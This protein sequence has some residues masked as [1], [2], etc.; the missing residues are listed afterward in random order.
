MSHL[1]LLKTRIPVN[2]L[3]PKNLETL[4]SE[5]SVTKFKKGKVIFKA[6]DTDDD[7][8]YLLEGQMELKPADSGSTR[9]VDADDDE[10]KYALAQLKPR[11]YTGKTVAPAIIARINSEKLDRLLSIDQMSDDWASTEGYEVTEFGGDAD[12]ELLVEMLNRDTFSQLPAESISELFSRLEPVS[13]KSNDVVIIQGEPGDY[14][15]IIK[16]GKFTVARKLPDGKVKKLAELGKGDVFGEEALISDKPRNASV[17]ATEEGEIMRLSKKD[18]DELLKPDL[19]AAISQ[20]EVRKLL[21]QGAALIDV[22]TADEFERGALRVAV[23][24]PLAMVRRAIDKLDNSRKYILCCQTGA[25]SSV[26]AFLLNQR[27]FEVYI[28]KGGLQGLAKQA[29]T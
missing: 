17:I 20:A 10:A 25:R 6:G 11:Q 4:D 7:V 19:V 27:G 15:Y 3:S 16:T 1:D 5:L 13:V 23:N 9:V 22:R 28:L 29:G 26:G 2:S 14:Y 21:K 18:F 12:T 8:I 24:I